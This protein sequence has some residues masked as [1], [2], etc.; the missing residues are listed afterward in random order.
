[1]ITKGYSSF[2]KTAELLNCSTTASGMT[3]SDLAC[4][5]LGMKLTQVSKVIRKEQGILRPPKASATA[6]RG[7]PNVKHE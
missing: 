7:N 2:L 4:S 5:C 1:M 6:Q 3:I